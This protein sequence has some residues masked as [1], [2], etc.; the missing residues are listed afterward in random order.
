M[1]SRP[2]SSLSP[3][4]AGA[5]PWREN[6]GSG[7]ACCGSEKPSCGSSR[8]SRGPTSAA[9][10]D[11]DRGATSWRASC[12]SERCPHVFDLAL[13][14]D[15]D[16]KLGRGHDLG[17]HTADVAATAGDFIISTRNAPLLKKQNQIPFLEDHP[18]FSRDHKQV[19]WSE[20]ASLSK[21]RIENAN[22]QMRTA[23]FG[24]GLPV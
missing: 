19:D 17:L 8:A 2:R 11:P 7:T 14:A 13:G 18:A 15:R 6:D 16:L 22:R 12:L 4:L 9:L 20:A 3:G 21:L 24:E 10:G 1:A 5:H 23:R